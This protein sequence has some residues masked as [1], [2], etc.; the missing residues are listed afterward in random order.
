MLRN[1]T[2]AKWKM[3]YSR[4][5]RKKGPAR[6]HRFRYVPLKSSLLGSREGS[7][8]RGEIVGF[9]KHPVASAQWPAVTGQGKKE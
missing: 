6:D 8:A 9:R 7:C 2:R 1:P 5:A 4:N 3:H